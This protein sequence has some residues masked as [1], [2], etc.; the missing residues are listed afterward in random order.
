MK[1]SAFAIAILI[2]FLAAASGYCAEVYYNKGRHVKVEKY[3]DI[4]YKDQTTITILVDQPVPG[5]RKPLAPG[6][7]FDSGH[8]IIRF[9]YYEIGANGERTKKV[10]YKGFYPIGK[11]T[12]ENIVRGEKLPAHIRDEKDVKYPEWDRIWNIAKVYI[13]DPKYTQ[14]VLDYYKNLEASNATFDILYANCA[15]VGVRALEAAGVTDTGISKHKLKL[16][17]IQKA[18][19]RKNGRDPS[20][21]ICYAAADI[22]E[23][24]RKTDEYIIYDKNGE[25]VLKHS[26]KFII[27]EKLSNVWAVIY[28]KIRS[29]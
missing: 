28:S 29:L 8:T 5:S 7:T 10:F 26:L 19:A 20:N 14:N 16:N 12:T 22:G 21:I 18:V 6:D 9:Q 24:I 2:L 4:N 25:V 23:D 27:K 3:F 11:L 17:S 1:R 13:V 15:S